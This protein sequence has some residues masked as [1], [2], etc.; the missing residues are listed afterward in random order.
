MKPQLFLAGLGGCLAGIAFAGAAGAAPLPVS[1]AKSRLFV[2]T[3]IANEPDDEG[4]LVRLLVHANEYDLEGIVVTT[5][6]WLRRGPREDLVRRQIDAYAQVHPNLLLHAPDYP[7]PE[8]LRRVVATGQTEFGLAAVG[9]GKATG[10][11]ELLLA[12]ARRDDPRPLWVAV[13]GGSNTLA[14]ALVDARR[15]LE[16]ETLRALIDRL[17]VY[18]IADQDDS[19]PWLRREFPDLFYIVS[20]SPLNHREYHRGTWS[21]I[22]GDRRYRNGPMHRFELVDN[23]WLERN[24][25]KGHGPL[26]ALYPPFKFIMEGD[27]PSFLGLVRNGLAWDERPD[28]GGWAGRYA[29]YQ[30]TGEVRKIWTNNEDSRDT[31]RAADGHLYTSDQATIWRWREAYQDEFAVRMDWCVRP[32]GAANHHPHAVVNGSAGRAVLRL[33]GRPGDQVTLDAAGSGDPDGDAIDFLWFHYPEAG[34]NLPVL[35]EIAF[36]NPRASRVTF[37]L[38]AVKRTHF[39]HFILEVCDGGAP[40]LRAYRRIIVEVEP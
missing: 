6:L 16:P 3:D 12:S 29:F 33:K 22:S 27:T 18:A 9:D 4:S 15:Q 32:H 26:G 25:I 19:G 24:V 37:P 5:S 20:P 13:W 23:P 14:Q 2:L 31:V 39:A 36:A 30:C 10:G 7:A 21:G 1:D 38:P 40:P 34:G 11:S 17:R 28:Y 8:Q 35:P